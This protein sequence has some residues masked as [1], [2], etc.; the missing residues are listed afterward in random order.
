MASEPLAEIELKPIESSADLPQATH[1]DSVMRILR[2]HVAGEVIRGE[3]LQ[4]KASTSC[5][6]ALKEMMKRNVTSAPVY[7]VVGVSATDDGWV[8]SFGPRIS[9]YD[10]IF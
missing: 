3:V 10:A 2:S 8:S 9:A 7:E 6:D 1:A 5:Y 4:F